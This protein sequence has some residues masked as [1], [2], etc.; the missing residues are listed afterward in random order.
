[1]KK[2]IVHHGGILSKIIFFFLILLSVDFFDCIPLQD[3]YNLPL[4]KQGLGA[5]LFLIGIPI[6]LQKKCSFRIEIVLIVCSFVFCALSSYI[7]Y[8]QSLYE[9]L[10]ISAG[11]LYPL[12]LYLFALRF[13]LSENYIYR[14]LVI[15]SLLML[16]ILFFQQFTYPYYVFCGR[17][18]QEWQKTLEIRMGLYRFTLHGIWFC[19]LCLM[20]TYHRF[21]NYRS[22]K[23][24]Y[25]LIMALVF[26]CI[27]F[28]LERKVLL[29]CLASLLVGVIYFKSRSLI[30]KISLSILLI[31][32]FVVL[33]EYVQELSEQTETELGDSNFIRFL[34]MR[35]YLFDMNSS[36]LYYI[37]GAGF[38]GNSALGKH[39]ETMEEVYHFYQEDV[40]II[41]YM[42]KVGVFGLSTY[43]LV[44]YKTFRWR[45]YIDR[46]LI[47]FVLSLLLVM[48]FKFWGNNPSNVAAFALFM[49]L[50]DAN[51]KKNVT[52]VKLRLK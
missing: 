27:L 34:S 19:V 42:S 15:F 17:V 33:P 20:L 13:R 8:S 26:T 14:V 25:V 22:L 16:A 11:Y 6:L 28:N 5:I 47:L 46:G 35:Y 43:F 10:K 49:Y 32:V 1:M 9:T 50:V 36:P 48:I 7:L 51:I 41:G 24:W 18:E 40:G 21:L 12:S 45:K 4:I 38:P 31:A 44:L 2:T 37:F 30:A 23:L 3:S 29:A 39:I 52:K